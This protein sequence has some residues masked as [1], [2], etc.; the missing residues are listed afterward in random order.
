MESIKVQKQN[1][2]YIKVTSDSGVEQELSEY[3]TFKVPGYK[4]V[5]SYRRGMW[6]GNIRLYNTRN[7][8][9]YGGLLEHVK[10]FAKDRG[11]EVQ[12]SENI[13]SQTEFSIHEANQFIKTLDG[14]KIDPRDYQIDAFVHAIRSNR[15]LLLSPTASGKSLIIY[16]ILRYLHDQ[17]GCK[18]ALIIVPNIAL[19]SQL[20]SDFADYGYDSNNLVH[21]I[22]SGQD[23][24]SN[25][26][27]TI[28][29]WQSLYKL[30][31]EFFRQFD[32]IIGD[33]AHQYKATSIKQLMEK[34]T[35]TRYRIGTTGT[36]DGTNTNKLVL[37][38]LF[39]PVYQVT[40]TKKLMDDKHVADF[41]I[42]TLILSYN[43]DERKQVK[44][45]NYADELNFIVTHDRRNKFITNLALSLEE[46]T[47]VL[48]QFIDKHG[49]VLYDMIKKET[50]RPVYFVDGKVEGEERERIRKIVDTQN[51]AIIIA[52]V[53]VFSTG[54]NI[55]SLKNI[56][57]TSP[58]KAR[59]RTL[60]SIGRVLRKSKTKSES[61]LFDIADDL[62]W[63]KKMN[64][65][66]L[67]FME[68]LK[69]YNSEQFVYK[70]YKVGLNK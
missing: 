60:Q 70:I 13:E 1:E 37:E 23:K 12:L 30:P 35:G 58:S 15:C 21:R 48:F 56:I 9:L 41:K 5:P 26:P 68:R 39:G 50:D 14:L 55:K 57:F 34:M 3:F 59:I 47:L 18:R 66:M 33:E 22:F 69:I 61:V 40:T 28:S 29:T 51:N 54:I 25:R 2:V 8:Q 36:L 38:G 7:K 19:V 4:F 44:G 31:E 67:H 63:K 64:Y 45:M 16:L 24:Q 43:D 11:Y 49:K 42:K 62:S 32:I 6:D 27:I 46:N 17:L 65:T 10:Q 20:A 52:S 53:G